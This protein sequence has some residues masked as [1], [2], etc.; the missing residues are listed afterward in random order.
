VREYF[1]QPKPIWG[2]HAGHSLGKI[3]SQVRERQRE[4]YFRIGT[5]RLNVCCEII[6]AVFGMGAHFEIGFLFLVLI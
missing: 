5:D 4:Y 1:F 3:L 6:L 2:S